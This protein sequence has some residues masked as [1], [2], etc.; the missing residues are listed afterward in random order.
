MVALAA[1]LVE[2]AVVASVA[3]GALARV[4]VAILAVAA[5]R[6][7]GRQATYV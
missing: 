1:G 7:I 5:H 2:E 4:A 3:A 6:A